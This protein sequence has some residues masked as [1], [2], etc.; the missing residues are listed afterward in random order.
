METAPEGLMCA[1]AESCQGERSR[2]LPSGRTG[3]GYDIA[4]IGGVFAAMTFVWLAVARWLVTHRTI[5][6][7]IRRYGGRVL[8]FVLIALGLYILYDTG[9]FGLLRAAR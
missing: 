8:P 3:S 7:P 6:V 2:A 9:T 4:V 1:S 5:G